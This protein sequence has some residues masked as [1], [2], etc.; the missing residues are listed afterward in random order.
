MAR[1]LV[2]LLRSFGGHT[3]P[4]CDRITV[5]YSDMNTPKWRRTKDVHQVT[6]THCIGV[7]ARNVE[8]SLD[9]P[10]LGGCDDGSDN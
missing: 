7:L 9:E 2:H 8:Q 10:R 3:W 1:K 4:A 6:C 5:P